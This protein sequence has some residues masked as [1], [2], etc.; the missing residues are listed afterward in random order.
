MEPLG[1]TARPRPHASITDAT[2]YAACRRRPA[3][4]TTQGALRDLGFSLLAWT[5]V[6]PILVADVITLVL[7]GVPLLRELESPLVRLGGALV[8]LLVWMGVGGLY[9][10]LMGWQPWQ[11]IRSP[12]RRVWR[13]PAPRDS[14]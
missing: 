10:G 1:E 3:L 13:G 5:C 11:A 4:P 9:G 7:W 2:G 6:F 8:V 14:I 12:R